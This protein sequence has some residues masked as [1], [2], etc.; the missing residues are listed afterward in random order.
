MWG[1]DKYRTDIAFDSSYFLH[2]QRNRIFSAVLLLKCFRS[3]MFFAW[4]PIAWTSIYWHDYDRK[5][6][7]KFLLTRLSRLL[8]INCT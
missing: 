5:A 4:K 8:H 7:I 1:E 6:T 3:V 2:S